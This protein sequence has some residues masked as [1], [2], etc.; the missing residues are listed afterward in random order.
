[1]ETAPPMYRLDRGPSASAS[2]PISGAPNGVPP[3][4]TS[5]YSAMTRPR[6]DG[7]DRSWHIEFAD[8]VMV[9]IAAPVG[10]S[11]AT[12][13]QY[14]G[15][16][17]HTNSSAPKTNAAPYNSR[18]LGRGRRAA[19]NAPMSEPAASAAESTPYD[20]ASRWN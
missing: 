9:R 3:R 15:T 17:A 2:T 6:M 19:A 18:C 7:A 14:D 11:I 10:T 16:N 1:M 4:K 20:A 8:V 5:T 12:S 13:S